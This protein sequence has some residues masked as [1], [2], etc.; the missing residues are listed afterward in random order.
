M[1]EARRRGNENKENHALVAIRV[2]YRR[3]QLR[4]CLSHGLASRGKGD[5]ARQDIGARLN[6]P[7]LALVAVQRGM[8]SGRVVSCPISRGPKALA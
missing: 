3:K 6:E 1:S 4:A 5:G 8:G 2:E 7:D